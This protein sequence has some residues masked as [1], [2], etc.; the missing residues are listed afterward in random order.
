M[1]N[2]LTERLNIHRTNKTLVWQTMIVTFGA[3]L[4]LLIKASNTKINWVEIF[5]MIMGFIL[6]LFFF[7]LIKEV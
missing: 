2:D 1:K 6:T 4:S 7:Y 3:T 5:L